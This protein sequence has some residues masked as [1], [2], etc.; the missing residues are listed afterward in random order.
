MTR[1]QYNKAA[2]ALLTSRLRTDPDFMG[3]AREAVAPFRTEFVCEG[4][5]YSIYRIPK[6][7]LISAY[8]TLAKLVETYKPSAP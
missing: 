2:S 5:G 6:D 4:Y 7:Q 3:L 1:R 8:Y